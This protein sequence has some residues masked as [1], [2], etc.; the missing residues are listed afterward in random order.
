MKLIRRAIG[1]VLGYLT[2][3]VTLIVC[4]TVA[5]I[6]LGA[7]RVFVGDTWQSSGIWNALS[8]V[9]GFIAGYI[10]GMVATFFGGGRSSGY[11][12]VFVMVVFGI[13]ALV[14]SMVTAVDP[15]PPA[16][17]AVMEFSGW[18]SASTYSRQPIWL[19][20]TTQLVGAFGAI[21][22]T[23]FVRSKESVK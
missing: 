12:L 7:D 5:A 9:L 3:A 6:L 15:S 20:V 8:I 18:M 1:V 4:M 21:R 17:P 16:R 10:G 19:L 11:G 14:I 22:G 2:V 13:A 23:R